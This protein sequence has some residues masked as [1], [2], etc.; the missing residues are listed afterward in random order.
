MMEDGELTSTELTGAF[1][2]QIERHDDEIFAYL[3]V[4]PEAAR[5]AAAAADASGLDGP[6]AGLPTAI[7]D[8]L[9][10]ENTVT[11]CGSRMLENFIPVYTATCIKQ[12]TDA[13]IV[14]LGK[15]NMDEFAMGSSTENSAF[16]T[17]RNP[18]DTERVPGGSSGG[19]AAAV[20]AGEALWAIGTDTG[21]SI[22]QP[23]SLCGVVGMK[24]TYGVVS[25]YGLVAFASSFDQVGP[26]TRSVKDAALMLRYLVGKDPLDSTSVRHPEGIA[27]PVDRDLS[28]LRIGIVSE[29]AGEGI[30]AGIRDCYEAALGKLEESGA[31]F[32]EVSL[33]HVDYSISAYYILAPA[34][35]SANLARYDGVRYGYRAGGASDV[36][37]MYESTRSQGFGDEV[38]RRIMLGTYALSSG[39]YDAYYGQAQKVR[40]LMVA[41]FNAAFEDFDLLVSP[42]TPTTAFRIGEKIDDPLSMYMSD[43][44][45]APANLAGLPAISIPAGLAE[46][47]PVGL[48][49]FGPAFSENR[50]LQAAHSAEMALGFDAVPPQLEAGD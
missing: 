33:P 9:C 17:T 11:T 10:T 41:D 26:I 44:C 28:G 50:L 1:L 49:L 46:G 47:L 34:E 2:D 37:E 40:S 16:G 19:S 42:T 29:L 45:T 36:T 27:E 12:M 20:A 23:A 3:H 13:G 6:L 21:G 30:D 8:V 4:D 48:Q 22:R 18:W 31:E 7:K 14:S 32:D 5:D 15:T 24:P 25:R 35:A 38:K 39:Y 43:V